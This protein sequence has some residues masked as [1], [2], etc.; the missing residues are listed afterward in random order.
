MKAL[1]TTDRRHLYYSIFGGAR[2]L[3]IA[4]NPSGFS[5]HQRSKKERQMPRA[6][7]TFAVNLQPQ[8]LSEQ[9]QA[10]T[11]G[12]LSIDKQFQGDLEAFSAGEMLSAVTPVEG[13]AGYVAMERV[14]GSLN[15]RSG[16]FILQHTGLMARGTPQLAITVVPDSGADELEG[17]AGTMDIIIEGGQ[18]RY[19]FEYT[20]PAAD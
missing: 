19:E 7:G 11:L 2:A 8:G 10:A 16:S 13:S 18:H 14:T 3:L 15:G 6:Q 9:G 12:R 4:R 5:H 20:L 17:I 1:F